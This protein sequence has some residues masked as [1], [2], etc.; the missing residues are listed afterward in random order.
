MNRLEFERRNIFLYEVIGAS[1]GVTKYLP[2]PT[3]S[4]P[5]SL[6]NW[7]MLFGTEHGVDILQGEI[8][9][10]DFTLS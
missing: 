3:P 4:P 5:Y 8:I 10:E 6:S 2:H 9:A 7:V 1:I